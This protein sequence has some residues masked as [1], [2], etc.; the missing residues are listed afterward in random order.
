MTPR[1]PTWEEAGL[2]KLSSAQEDL[3]AQ[4]SP[5]STCFASLSGRCKRGW[6]T[7]RGYVRLRGST[8]PLCIARPARPATALSRKFDIPLLINRLPACIRQL[9]ASTIIARSNGGF[10][11]G[12]FWRTYPR[13]GFCFWGEHANVL[14][15]RFRSGGTSEC[16]LVPVFVLGGEHRPKPPFWK[17]PFWQPPTQFR[18]GPESIS[19][20]SVLPPPCVV[21]GLH[22]DQE[23]DCSRKVDKGPLPLNTGFRCH[24][25]ARTFA[26]RGARGV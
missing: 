13:S 10:V 8:K 6:V 5:W 22:P 16:T 23:R 11:K 7:E 18:N 17:P 1:L 20:V 12:W 14:S 9:L 3:H 4:V 24:G 26:A 21:Q 19:L 2:G 25:R 15:F